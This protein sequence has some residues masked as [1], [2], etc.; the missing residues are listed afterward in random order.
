MEIHEGLQLAY[1]MGVD[2]GHMDALIVGVAIVIIFFVIALNEKN[3]E[4]AAIR[5]KE[6]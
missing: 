1:E 6:E 3:Y 5:A 2:R 4:K